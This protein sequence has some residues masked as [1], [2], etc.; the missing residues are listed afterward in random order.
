MT[1]IHQTNKKK[2]TSKWVTFVSVKEAWSYI[3]YTGC[4][5]KNTFLNSLALGISGACFYRFLV[6]CPPRTQCR[7]ADMYPSP[8]LSLKGQFAYFKSRWLRVQVKNIM[9]WL[10]YSPL[11]YWKV[12]AHPQLPGATK[13][14]E[15][16]L[17]NWEVLRDDKM[18]GH[19]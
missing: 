1:P 11:G 5:P 7:Q 17:N 9:C 3:W 2:P 14:K 12:S 13:N 18:V 10:T 19:G 8:S 16:H 15:Y 6:G 4:S